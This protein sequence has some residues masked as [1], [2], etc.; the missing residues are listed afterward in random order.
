M[1]RDRLIKIIH[2]EDCSD[3]EIA[4]LG[5]GV[6]FDTSR[7]L[8]TQPKED[9]MWSH[10]SI[11]LIL[12]ALFKENS[13]GSETYTFGPPMIAQL[14]GD[15]R[16]RGIPIVCFFIY[17]KLKITLTLLSPKQ[18]CEDQIEMRKVRV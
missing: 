8:S 4:E 16:T 12:G 11:F 6:V 1:W 2:L 3:V 18:V 9:G 10:V 17:N 14:Q 15:T 5:D 7:A 13:Y